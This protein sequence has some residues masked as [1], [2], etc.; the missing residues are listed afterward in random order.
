[1]LFSCFSISSKIRS[2]TNIIMLYCSKN[3]LIL[4]IDKTTIMLLYF[5][6]IALHCEMKKRPVDTV[7]ADDDYESAFK[8]SLIN[9]TSICV[10]DAKCKAAY[11]SNGF[12]FIIYKDDPILRS[13][14]GSSYFDKVCNRKYDIWHQ[15]RVSIVKSIMCLLM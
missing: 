7:G 10:R 12:C 5:Y 15:F 6:L 2:F 9:C 8:S 1:M 11:Y 14:T 4:D 13:Y 3:P